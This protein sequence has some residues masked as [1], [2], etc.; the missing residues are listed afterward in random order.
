MVQKLIIFI[1]IYIAKI[2]ADINYWQER[3]YEK[4]DSVLFIITFKEKNNLNHY[5]VTSSNPAQ[6]TNMIRGEFKK[7]PVFFVQAFKIIVDS[8]EFSMLLLYTLWDDWPIS[9]ISGSS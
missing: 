6:L 9:M 3:N 4:Q 1:D 5:C 8:W 7:F 2:S